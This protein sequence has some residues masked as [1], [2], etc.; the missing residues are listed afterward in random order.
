MEYTA[1]SIA[2]LLS[3]DIIGDPKIKVVTISKIQEAKPG[4]LSFLANPAY[5]SFLYTTTASIVL[6]NKNSVP[7]EKVKPTL[8]VVEDAY[9]AFATLVD[10]Y[11]KLK[12]VDKA[13]IEEMAF[14]HK[15]AILGGDIFVGSFSYISA[16]AVIGDNVKIYPQVYIGENVQIGDNT[17]IY[18]GVKIY[19]DCVVGQNCII[20][21][22]TVIGGD[23]FGFAPQK[24]GTFLKIQ[25][26]GNVEIEDNVEIG[27]N[28]SIDRA[29]LGSTIIRS[30]V[31]LDNLIQI[32]HN[33]EVGENTVIAAQAGVAG[34]TKIGRN[35][36]IG[37]QAGIV[38]HIKIA[39][40]TNVGAQAGIGKAII[41]EG[42]TLLGSPSFELTK[43]H[44]SYSVFKNLPDL[45]NEII[46]LKKEIELLK[47]Q[48]K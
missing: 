31:K 25:Q 46:E 4:S 20:H 16:N 13:G 2:E 34:S 14:I 18:P 37:G 44:R 33:V 42:T 24:D 26:I 19:H 27:S 39:D 10:I 12:N 6:I 38:G 1:K 17:I 36:L 22:G 11:Q 47:K 29:T 15:S 9:K 28:A 45:R 41:K 3:G 32:A 48:T 5:E 23:G 7:K 43:F 21:S 30:G 40:K 35:C 8:I